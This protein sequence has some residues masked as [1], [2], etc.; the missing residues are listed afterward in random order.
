MSEIT[1]ALLDEYADLME[2]VDYSRYSW[3]GDVT[4]E[5]IH[6]ATVV[7]V[8]ELGTIATGDVLAVLARGWTE[9][10]DLSEL[11]SQD[12]G[13]DGA[14][15]L[16]SLLID[17]GIPAD[18]RDDVDEYAGKTLLARARERGETVVWYNDADV[19]GLRHV[20]NI[21]IFNKKG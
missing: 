17:F 4:R 6:A 20:P 12:D 14:D 1:I 15:K 8:R 21:V 13:D 3:G 7:A 11:C 2:D 10:Q 9:Y 18:V 19:P 5:L 16:N